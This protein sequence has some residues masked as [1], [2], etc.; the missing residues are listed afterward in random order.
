MSAKG[1]A[2]SYRKDRRVD[3][4]A[5][6][7]AEYVSGRSWLVGID[8]A[9]R[10]CLAGPVCAAAVAVRARAYANPSFADALCL[11]DD[12]KKLSEK[13]R[14]AVYEKLRILKLAGEIDF[15]AAFASVEEIEK[16]N[17]LVATQIAMARAARALDERLNLSL[18]G[19]SSPAT[20][21]GESA[22]D[23]STGYVLI[24]GRPMKKFPYAHTAVVKG[25]A[26]SLAIASA[27]I[28]AKV[29]RDNF[30]ADLS[31]DYPRYSFKV[32]KGYGTASHLQGLLLFGA[33]PAHRR[34]FLKK[35]RG[36]TR[37]GGR[38]PELF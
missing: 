2:V 7:D 3:G 21:F 15:E 20:L 24:D 27:S 5:A 9:G 32:N 4:L 6:F 38:Q 8:E 19:A 28:V 10:G 35:L 31:R 13:Q 16:H 14:N 22:V 17:I 29:T 12:S 30:M 26:S 18:R 37:E 36:R 1:V 33:C 34:S 11:L 25:D 23:A